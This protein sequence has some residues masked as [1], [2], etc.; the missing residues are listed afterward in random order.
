V[1]YMR[2]VLASP[3]SWLRPDLMIL[4]IPCAV[5]WKMANPFAI[6]W[7]ASS[8][9]ATGGSGPRDGMIGDGG[10]ARPDD[11]IAARVNPDGWGCWMR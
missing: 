5:S 9:M 7:M 6:S 3:E 1:T 4:S 10:G 2:S 8:V 11:R